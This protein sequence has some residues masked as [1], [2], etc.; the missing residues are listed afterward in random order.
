MRRRRAARRQLRPERGQIEIAGAE[1][2]VERRIR[3]RREFKIDVVLGSRVRFV[4][5][6]DVVARMRE[7]FAA[8]LARHRGN[9]GSEGQLV[10]LVDPAQRKR[11]RAHAVAQRKERRVRDQNPHRRVCF[12]RKDPRGKTIALILFEQRRIAHLVEELLVHLIRAKTLDDFAFHQLAVHFFREARDRG[13]RRQRARKASFDAARLRIPKTNLQ[14]GEREHPVNRGAR[15]EPPQIG[16]R[17]PPA[18]R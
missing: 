18:A 7:N 14:L 5:R 2:S 15:I 8:R 10:D 3:Q 6:P 17:C 9:G 11:E 16:N 12:D 1:N 13:V 4:E